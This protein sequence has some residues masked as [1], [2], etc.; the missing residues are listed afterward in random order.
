MVREVNIL[1]DSS[2]L[3]RQEATKVL[4]LLQRFNQVLGFLV[5]ERTGDSI[6]QDLLDALEK[7]LQARRDKNWSLA[8]SLRDLIHS[9]GYTIE[10]TP[11][12]ARLKKQ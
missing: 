11:A 7:R 2:R 5:F 4:N 9:R 6:P 12:G 1:C 3:G 8:D 10:D